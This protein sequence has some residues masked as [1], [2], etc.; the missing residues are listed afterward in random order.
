VSAWLVAV[1]V[2]EVL[3]VTVGAR[4]RPALEMVPKEADH[5]TAT[6]DVFVTDAV[7]CVDAPEVSVADVGVMVI[8][9]PAMTVRVRDF[10]DVSFG[11]EES[12]TSM[13]AVND[14]VCE[15]VPEIDPADCTVIPVGSEPEESVQV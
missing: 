10:D 4:Y 8:A 7:N 1:T 13:V 6:F 12:L 14:P 2:A 5:V 11:E 15:V 9:T 3:E